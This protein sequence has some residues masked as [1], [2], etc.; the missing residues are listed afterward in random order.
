M[1][2]IFLALFSL[3][4][5]YPDPATLFETNPMLYKEPQGHYASENIQNVLKDEGL[6]FV[7]ETFDSILAESSCLARDFCQFGAKEEARFDVLKTGEITDGNAID[8]ITVSI[9]LILNI[10]K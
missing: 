6:L 7:E 1:I 3:T 9:N 4:S 10:N 5:A 8:T 2:S